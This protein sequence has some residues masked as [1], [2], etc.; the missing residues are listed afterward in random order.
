MIDEAY[1]LNGKHEQDPGRIVVQLLMDLL[2]DEG[3]RDIA[4]VLC[5]Y[6]E[7]MMRLLDT[8]PGLQSRFPNRFEFKDFSVD[9][10]LEISRRRVDEY[11]YH[12]TPQ[13]WQ[14]YRDVL[15]EAYAVRDPQSWGNARFVANQLERIY[16]QHARRCTEGR[17]VSDKQLLTLTPADIVPI[18]VARAPRHV[19]F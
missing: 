2:A 15:S 6:K 12:F 3:R 17:R 16:I 18:E 4:V 14:K 9:D 8:N 5:G 1:L 11:Q 19:G 7:P 10:L 13:A